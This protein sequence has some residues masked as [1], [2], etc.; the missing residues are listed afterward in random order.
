MH[1]V[2]RLMP[3]ISGTS[4]VFRI[5]IERELVIS[6]EARVFI[7]NKQRTIKKYQTKETPRLPGSLIK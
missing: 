5:G 7:K 3:T 2:T 4:R 6:E 1:E